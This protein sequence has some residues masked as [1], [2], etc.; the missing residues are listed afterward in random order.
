MMEIAN[1]NSALDPD[2]TIRADVTDIVKIIDN[3][4]DAHGRNDALRAYVFALRDLQRMHG[5]HAITGDDGGIAPAQ[6]ALEKAFVRPI[7]AQFSLN[8]S[9]GTN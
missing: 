8:Q 5:W 2:G 6:T 4:D 7:V 9:A 3:I 1:I